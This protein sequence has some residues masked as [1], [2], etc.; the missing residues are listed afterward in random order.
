M[1]ACACVC[2]CVCERE[3]EKDREKERGAH[4]VNIGS[5]AD[6]A[7]TLEPP[8]RRYRSCLEDV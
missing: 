4:S 1:I 2:V 6:T 8:M 7:P 3:R 5:I